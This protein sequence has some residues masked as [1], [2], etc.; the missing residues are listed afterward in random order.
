MLYCP[1]SENEKEFISNNPVYFGEWM[2]IIWTH[3]LFNLRNDSISCFVNN[4][5]ELAL[6]RANEREFF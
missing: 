4:Q 1:Q 5:T 3:V 2:G 6:F